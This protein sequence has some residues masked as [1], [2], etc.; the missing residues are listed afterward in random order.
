MEKKIIYAVAISAI[1]VI[2]SAGVLYVLANEN[3]EPRQKYP[4]YF[5]TMLVSNMKGSLASGGIDGFIA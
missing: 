4:V 3:K 2:A 5:T 1:I